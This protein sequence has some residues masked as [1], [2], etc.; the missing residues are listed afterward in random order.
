MLQTC[1]LP[2]WRVITTS[3]LNLSF[4]SITI[5]GR[6]IFCLIFMSW[7]CVFVT[8]PKTCLWW[9]MP[10]R[11]ISVRL[12]LWLKEESVMSFMSYHFPVNFYFKWRT[13]GK[14]VTH[15]PAHTQTHTRPISKWEYGYVIISVVLLYLKKKSSFLF[16]KVIT[17]FKHFVIYLI[18]LPL[19]HS[20][21]YA[22]NAVCPFSLSC[23]RTT[24]SAVQ[25]SLARHLPLADVDVP[26]V[27]FSSDNFSFFKSVVNVSYLSNLIDDYSLPEIRDVALI[28]SIAPVF[29]TV[30]KTW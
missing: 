14:H 30:P 24:V 12:F 5:N 23:P 18:S 29:F 8:I 26:Y 9:Q 20:T 10:D 16:C 3:N 21:A 6:R 25:N 11:N 13:L 7:I 4:G 2:R 19:V 22:W 15:F 27:C 1:V 28:I 17:V